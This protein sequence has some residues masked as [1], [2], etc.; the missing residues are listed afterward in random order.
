M[1]DSRRPTR[2]PVAL[3]AALFAALS[4]CGDDGAQAQ[5][6]GAVA[7]APHAAPDPHASMDPHAA[8]GGLVIRGTV[9]LDPA[10]GLDPAAFRCLYLL[11][12]RT[13]G[14][15][16]SLVKKIEP[17]SLPQ[18]FELQAGGSAGGD[19]SYIVSARLDQDGDAT[20]ALG[21]V[22][23]VSST[24]GVPGGAPLAI[25]LNQVVDAGGAA[26]R[27]APETLAPAAAPAP[28]AP[29]AA[30]VDPASPRFRGEVR[31]APEFA[32]LDGRHPLF[33]MLRSPKTPGGMPLA[34]QKVDFARFPLAF[35]MGAEN[36]PLDVDNKDEI[37]A[38]E[39]RI[40]ARL[41]VSGKITGGPG[42]IEGELLSRPGD[43]L[44]VDLA[45][46]RAQ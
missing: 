15:P 16:A 37:I 6:G 32:A 30:A 22:E 38:G 46:Q 1:N 34:V 14:G 12:R 8:A 23:G 31:L 19:A 25:V 36:V 21:D 33:I 39:I 18:D 43:G 35:D 41:S 9:S 42:D 44:I 11:G 24:P 27:P 4:A 26:P 29:A 45:K 3:V 20:V 13:P 5:G 17:V 28:A 40:V 7:A 10:L 2:V